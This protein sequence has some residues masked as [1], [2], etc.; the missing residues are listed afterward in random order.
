M[1]LILVREMCYLGNVLKKPASSTVAFHPSQNVERQ[2]FTVSCE[3]LQGQ[4][5]V[6]L[7]IKWQAIFGGLDLIFDC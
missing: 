4:N 6:Y 5:L 1:P 3:L 2:K 7:Q